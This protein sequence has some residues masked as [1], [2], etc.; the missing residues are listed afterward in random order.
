MTGTEKDASGGWWL[1]A[2]IAALLLAMTA[3]IAAFKGTEVEGT[4]LAIR[5]T[6][7]TSLVLFLLAFTASATT[8]LFPSAA[9]SWQ[10]RNRRYLGLSFAI[11]HL[12]HGGG[13]PSSGQDRSAPFRS[14]DQPG[15]FHCRGAGLCCHRAFGCDL[16]RPGGHGSGAQGLDVAAPRRRLVSVVVLH[17]ELR[18]AN[19]RLSRVLVLRGPAAACLGVANLGLASVCIHG[20]LRGAGIN[21]HGGTG[22]APGLPPPHAT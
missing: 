6:A 10:R 18:Q 3:A 16:V 14:V 8:R 2:A 15:I 11:S 9:T 5:M 13:D 19:S 4:R 17:R 7:R 22:K 21:R 1:T 20:P 12:I